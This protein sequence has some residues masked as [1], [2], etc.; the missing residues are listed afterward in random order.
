M[1][2]SKFATLLQS[3]LTVSTS[4]VR[5]CLLQVDHFLQTST[6][7][8]QA[9]GDNMRLLRYACIV[10]FSLL[11]MLKTPLLLYNF[12]SGCFTRFVFSMICIYYFVLLL[13]YKGFVFLLNINDITFWK[14]VIIDVP[15]K[16]VSIISLFEKSF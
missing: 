7:T 14:S 13:L 4:Q 15:L 12:S 2:S 6:E 9:S 3:T 11:P 5:G 1:G 8:M 10:F 16:Y